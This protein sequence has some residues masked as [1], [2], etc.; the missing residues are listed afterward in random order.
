MSAVASRFLREAIGISSPPIASRYLCIRYER[1]LLDRG[2]YR[3]RRGRVTA[4]VIE[5]PVSWGCG[6]FFI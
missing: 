4:S 6:L 5:V 2:R 3:R 1:A